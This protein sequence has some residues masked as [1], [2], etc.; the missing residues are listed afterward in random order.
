MTGPETRFEDDPS[1]TLAE[2]ES[3]LER[4]GRQR[5]D[6]I[7][8][9]RQ[10]CDSFSDVLRAQLAGEKRK[11][12]RELQTAKPRLAGRLERLRS[13]HTRI[14]ENLG[15][16]IETVGG[17]H[18]GQVDEVDDLTA[19]VRL[20]IADAQR[21]DAKETELLQSAYWREVGVGD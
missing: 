20:L 17:L 14:S 12:F 11:L 16:V 13:E 3:S 15:A 7:A 4:V 10:C 21:H 9:L 18:P 2:L 8:R 19:R 1:R 6:R 5:D